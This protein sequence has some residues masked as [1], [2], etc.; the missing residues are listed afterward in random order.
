[1]GTFRMG[2]RGEKMPRTSPPPGRGK[3]GRD[4][5]S[6]HFYFYFLDRN[7]SLIQYCQKKK[8]RQK[9]TGFGER[10]EYLKL[11]LLTP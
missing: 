6:L 5:V 3:A 4:L 8:E 1:M 7:A 9:N 10:A 2:S 11:S